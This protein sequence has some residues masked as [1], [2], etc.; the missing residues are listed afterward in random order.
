[1]CNVYIWFWP[2]LVMHH[3]PY[4]TQTK[5]QVKKAHTNKQTQV[6]KTQTL[7]SQFGVRSKVQVRE[8]SRIL[9]SPK[10]AVR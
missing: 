1:M 2:F 5:T 4:A 3:I 8:F 9:T 6:Y 7:V 10:N